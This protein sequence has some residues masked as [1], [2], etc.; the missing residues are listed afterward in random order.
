MRQSRGLAFRVLTMSMRWE[1]VRGW[2]WIAASA[3]PPRN[4]VGAG[5]APHSPFTIPDVALSTHDS[6][7]KPAG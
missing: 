3:A 6:G 1:I 7:G 4:D 2:N 5:V